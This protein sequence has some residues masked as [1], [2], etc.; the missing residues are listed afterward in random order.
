M[1][2]IYLCI[3]VHQMESPVWKY[4]KKVRAED[5][6]ICSK[7]NKTLSCKGST[8]SSLIRHLK[9][10]HAIIREFDDENIKNNNSDT[11]KSPIDVTK[12]RKI[13]T[14]GLMTAFL[15]KT[16]MGEILAKLVAIDGLSIHSIVKSSF[17][18]E[19][20]LR[21]GYSLPKNNKSIMKFIVEFY[22]EKKQEMVEYFQTLIKENRKFS[23]TLDEWSSKRNRRYLNVNIHESDGQPYNLGLVRIYGSCPAEKTMEL[24][25][26]KLNEFHLNFSHIIGCTT[27]GAAVMVK[28]GHLAPIYHQLCYNHGVHLAVM[29]VLCKK[30]S[31]FIPMKNINEDFNDCES[32]DSNIS[33]SDDENVDIVRISADQQP[34]QLCDNYKCLLGKVRKIVKLFKVSPLKNNILQKYVKDEYGE[35][36]EFSALLDCRTRWNSIQVMLERFLK[37]KNSIKKALIDLKLEH[38][39]IEEDDVKNIE[40]L[41]NTLKPITMA[42]NELSRRNMNLLTS[43]GVFKFLFESLETQQTE[44]SNSMILSLKLRLEE[45]RN[46]NIISIINFLQNPSTVKDRF[47]V[48]FGD[49]FRMNTKAEIIKSIKELSSKFLAINAYAEEVDLD[50]E[51]YLDMGHS[52]VSLSEK[53]QRSIENCLKPMN[54]KEKANQYYVKEINMFESTGIITPN[55]SKLFDYLK[56]IQPTSTESERVF[57]MASNLVTMKRQNL[58]DQ[59][60]TAILFLRSYFMKCK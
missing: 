32:D 19:S 6:A 8:T 50:E 51:G 2:F 34:V 37:I 58:S 24:V 25:E 21:Q 20:F 13:E 18:R 9:T 36:K 59:S 43:E 14:Q 47:T 15:K 40:T 31:E 12:K 3:L 23:L 33:E 7:C 41:S 49:F 29:D 57:S 30:S 52:E 48:K 55:L 5:K 16:S 39:F 53:L 54:V 22:Y 44:F 56:T 46:K 42:V 10:N 28:F 17:I 1:K 45:R 4:F 38:L 60:I 11:L 27:D 35:G 26:N